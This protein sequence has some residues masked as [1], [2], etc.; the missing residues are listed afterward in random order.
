MYH[1]ICILILYGLQPQATAKD[2]DCFVVN[3]SMS[4]PF[5]M[6]LFEQFENKFTYLLT[7]HTSGAIPELGCMCPPI[8]FFLVA[9]SKLRHYLSP[10]PVSR[11]V[12]KKM[13]YRRG[14]LRISDKHMKSSHL[15]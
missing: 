11:Q 13:Y 14:R 9:I 2:T 5:I 1:L 15:G 3:I 4:S 6:S 10:S 8:F 7:I 12:S